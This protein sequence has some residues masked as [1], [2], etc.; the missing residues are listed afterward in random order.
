MRKLQ[1]GVIGSAGPEEYP[2]G[3]KPDKAIF[4]ISEELGRLIARNGMILITGGKGGIMEAACRGAKSENGITVGVVKG[5]DRNT[6]NGYV[7]VE[8]VSGMDGCGEESMLVLMCD[9]LISV[10]GGAGTLQ[11][12]TI[13]YR[14]AKPA[15]LLD[16]VPGWSKTL[17][18]KY[19]DGRK[20]IR[21]RRAKTAQKAVKI[22]LKELK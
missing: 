3:A 11:E 10:G 1:I 7:D 21:M 19:L 8:V 5:K 22:L 18:G 15:V 6:S 14:N 12:L 4:D 20:T 9:G 17:S 16:T 2:R 13:A